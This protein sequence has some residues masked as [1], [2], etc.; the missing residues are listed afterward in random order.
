[1]HLD[2]AGRLPLA[3]A[4]VV[5]NRNWRQPVVDMVAVV[6]SSLGCVR[7]HRIAVG[8]KATGLDRSERVSGVNCILS[9]SYRLQE[10]KF[11]G[12]DLER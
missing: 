7:F 2:G 4:A 1:M 6:D 5:G 3:A 12:Y 10:I 9:L 11:L 8:G